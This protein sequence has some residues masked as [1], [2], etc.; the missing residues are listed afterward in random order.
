MLRRLPEIF[1]R[2]TELAMKCRSRA[3]NKNSWNSSCTK[4]A[5]HVMTPEKKK[6]I[7]DFPIQNTAANLIIYGVNEFVCHKALLLDKSFSLPKTG[8]G[9]QNGFF[10][11]FTSCCSF[12]SIIWILISK[13]HKAPCVIYLLR[14]FSVFTTSIYH[15]K[16]RII[17]PSSSF[18][19]FLA[20]G[21][22]Y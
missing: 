11:S 13:C 18:S 6:Y 4:K 17:C 3:E 12:I 20:C 19:V 5:L 2:S 8:Q 7:F 9:V 16:F 15:I 21:L 22:N 14:R 10:F 1:L